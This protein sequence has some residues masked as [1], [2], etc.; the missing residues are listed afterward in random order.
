L[1]YNAILLGEI[2][3]N[4][5][6][7]ALSYTVSQLWPWLVGSCLLAAAA[8]VWWLYRKPYMDLMRSRQK[9]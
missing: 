3:M 4:S 9:S 5:S 6:E 2:H 7:A 1:L 8:L